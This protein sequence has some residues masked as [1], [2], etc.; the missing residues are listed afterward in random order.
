MFAH[1]NHEAIHNKDYSVVK[2][3]RAAKVALFFCQILLLQKS[4]SQKL[5]KGNKNHN[6]KNYVFS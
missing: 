3:F 5:L 6:Y 1:T 4:A 2:T